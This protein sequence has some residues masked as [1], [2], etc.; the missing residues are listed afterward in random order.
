MTLAEVEA[1]LSQIQDKSIHVFLSVNDK[2]MP[3]TFVA[4]VWV[5][6]NQGE[7]EIVLIRDKE[8]KL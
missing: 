3:A 8:L 1:V 2:L 5:T 7:K 4:Q 6:T